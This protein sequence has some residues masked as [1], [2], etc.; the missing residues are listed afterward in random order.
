[1]I[2]CLAKYMTAE[3]SRE[4]G[5]GRNTMDIRGNIGGKSTVDGK[6]EASAL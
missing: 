5:A 6:A 3:T 1:M 4:N 2:Y